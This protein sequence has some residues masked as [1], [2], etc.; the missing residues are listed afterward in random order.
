MSSKMRYLFWATLIVAS[1]SEAILYC[2]LGSGY[3]AWTSGWSSGVLA[4][5]V[6]LVLSRR[7][8]ARIVVSR[9][10]LRSLRD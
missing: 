6:L 7:R 9:D 4:Y 3:F 5:D 8:V 10:M 2:K 1:I